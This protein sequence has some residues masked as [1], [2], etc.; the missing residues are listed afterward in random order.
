MFYVF[1]ISPIYA[2]TV[3]LFLYLHS[4]YSF[5]NLL[6][7]KS[8]VY[9]T[10]LI[11]I[12]IAILHLLGSYSYSRLILIPISHRTHTYSDSSYAVLS[13]YIYKGTYA[14]TTSIYLILVQISSRSY[15]AYTYTKVLLHV[16]VLLSILYLF[17]SLIGVTGLILIQR[18]P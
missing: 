10:E 15:R 12:C 14:H 2:F 9:G 5:Y 11:L 8:L 13:L 18:Y 16:L 17:K 7:F 4:P 1:G 6:L 3:F